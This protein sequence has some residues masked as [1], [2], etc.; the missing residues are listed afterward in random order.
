MATFSLVGSDSLYINNRLLINLPHG[1]VA[2]VTYSTD[3]VTVKTGKSGNTIFAQNSSGF[4]ATME[5]K[6]TRGSADD[7]YM[8]TE[9]TSYRD[10]ATGYVLMNAEIVKLIGDGEGKVKSDNYVL[11]GGIIS[12]QVEV[13]SNV[14]GDVEQ[15]VSSYTIQFAVCTRVVG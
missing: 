2:K 5:L 4:Q 13:T 1:E 12:K 11:A 3:L 10:D 9:L 15:A 7:K 14:E 6:L 8:Q